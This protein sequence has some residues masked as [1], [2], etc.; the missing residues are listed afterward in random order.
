MISIQR[1]VRS[2]QLHEVLEQEN[3]CKTQRPQEQNLKIPKTLK[4]THKFK[5]PC[6]LITFFFYYSSLAALLTGQ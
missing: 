2:V 4:L 5:Q 1:T 6:P 3:I